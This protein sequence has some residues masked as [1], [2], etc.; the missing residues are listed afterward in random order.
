MQTHLLAQTLNVDGQ[1]ISGPAGFAL[2]SD[3]IG[4]IITKGLSYVFAFAGL[5]LL[6]MIITSG[7]T[8]MLAAGDPKKMAKGKDTLT[9]AIIGFLVIFAAFWIVQIVGIAL[10]WQGIMGDSGGL[11]Q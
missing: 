7:F 3:S 8:L 5:G 2:A 1:P 9:N 10:G 4:S 6:L 11:F